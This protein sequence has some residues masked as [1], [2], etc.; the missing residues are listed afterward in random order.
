MRRN[1]S[2]QTVIEGVMHQ[3][4]VRIAYYNIYITPDELVLVPLDSGIAQEIAKVGGLVTAVG[5]V[6]AGDIQRKRLIKQLR[7]MSLS[8]I[9]NLDSAIVVKANE[10]RVSSGLL[11][12]SLSAGGKNLRIKNK[13]AKQVEVALSASP[14]S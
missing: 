14:S 10:V 9:K 3:G 5:A 13:V 6:V 4:A 2:A 1:M 12:S 11:R 7:E 8:D